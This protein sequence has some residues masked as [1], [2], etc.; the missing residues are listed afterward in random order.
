M[1]IAGNRWKLLDM[2]ANGWNGCQWLEMVRI[3]WT[4]L[5]W[6]EMAGNGWKWLELSGLC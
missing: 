6:L 1:E 5:E 3:V 2:A 4:L